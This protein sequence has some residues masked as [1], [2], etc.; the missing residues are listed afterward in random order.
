MR[1]VGLLV[2]VWCTGTFVCVYVLW[3]GDVENRTQKK[4]LR[5]GNYLVMEN[6]KNLFIC[7]KIH[8]CARLFVHRP[9]V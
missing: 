2:A 4:F 5:P 7:R 1:A 8:K 3:G 9:M 6:E